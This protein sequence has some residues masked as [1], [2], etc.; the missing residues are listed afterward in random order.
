[1]YQVMEAAFWV[2]VLMMF[3][4]YVG[5]PMFVYVV[6]R[7]I[8][9]ATAAG[10]F[11]PSVTVLITAYNE[12][13]DI[14]EKIENTLLL[15]YPSDKL[16]VVVASDGSTDATDEIVKKFNGR[17]VRLFRQ[18]GRVGKTET[19]N[20]AVKQAKG[21]VILFSDATTMYRSDVLRAIMPNFADDRIGCV[22]GK[23]IYVDQ[24]NSEVGAGAKS[25][26][27]YETFLKEN[28]SKA[29]SLIG[30]SGCMY[31]VRKSAYV[32]MYP[33]ACSDFLI[34]TVVYRQGLR[35]VFEPN[36]VCYE[37]INDRSDKEFQMRVRIISQTLTD[38]WRNRDM[39]NPFSN[40]L[41]ALQLASHKMARYA[42]PLFL[43]IVFGSALYLA[44][45]SRFFQLVLG[46]Q[47]IFY[48][49]AFLVWASRGKY[50]GAGVYAIPFYFVLGNLA[51]IRGV[52]KFLKGDRYQK[53]EPFRTS[54]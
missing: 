21:E 19:Q 45:D 3:Y 47:T 12:E 51:I 36:A 6:A 53:W 17:G 15:E 13:R 31:A 54:I 38:L 32:P 33:E 35:S 22:A 5:Y 49:C 46:T 42:V 10:P 23:L 11:E 18:E 29:C 28:E 30:V 2:S 34:C 25:Y 26:W 24:V 20:N 39:M 52:I 4:T 7:I 44:A 9:K 48:L 8:P 50:G 14:K 43:V 16:E 1:M 41:F 37:D 40:G 27:N